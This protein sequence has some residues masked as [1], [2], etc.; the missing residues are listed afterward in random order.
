MAA[1][2]GMMGL[3]AFLGLWLHD[4]FGASPRDVGLVFLI[5]GGAA[6]AASPFAGAV[7]DR[8]GKKSQ[9][10]LAN[11]ALAVLVVLL[12]RLSWGWPLYGIFC[13]ISLA[14]AFRQGPMEALVTEVVPAGQRASFVALK[15]SCSQVGIALATAAS[16]HLLEQGGYGRVC[17]FS[18]ALSLLAALATIG[19]VRREDL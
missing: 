7:S 16:G 17:L 13:A 19:L 10:V 4:R 11:A 9:F 5:S 8:I 14:S 6:L 3:L 1:S 15:N 12:P 18:A 2:G